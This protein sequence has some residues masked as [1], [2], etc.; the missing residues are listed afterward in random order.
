MREGGR[1]SFYLLIAAGILA[2]AFFSLTFIIN[3]SLSLANASWQWTA[4]LRYFFMVPLLGALLR[5]TGKGELTRIT[6]VVGK[7][8]TPWIIGGTVGF[9][10]F[11]APLTFAAAYGPAWLVAGTWQLTILIGGLL[12]PWLRKNPDHQTAI[13]WHTLR[14][15][16]VILL[17]IGLLQWSHVSKTSNWARV[18]PLV[19]P[20]LIAAT[21]Y[22]VGNR[23]MLAHR[24][25]SLGTV[26]RTYG[27]T[28]GSLPFWLA[29]AVWGYLRAGWP[30][31]G[32]LVQSILVALSSGVIAT[33]LFYWATEKAYA[34]PDQLAA[35]EATQ[36]AEV[37]F[38]AI[39]AVLILG[40]PWPSVMALIG[41]G[42][43]VIGLMWHSLSS[44]KKPRLASSRNQDSA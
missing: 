44:H 25:S 10:F 3:Q 15:S 41:I 17:G 23:W 21:A 30:T 13:P 34:R 36:S 38:A 31:T 28:L 9:G 32:Q 37:V 24:A 20:L 22:P 40:Q 43:I 5:V 29:V 7:N 8:P 2:S 16:S 35:V 12:E 1:P 14:V 11:Y 42:C 18:L 26:A 6:R 39:G 4:A 33:L 19:I 27:M